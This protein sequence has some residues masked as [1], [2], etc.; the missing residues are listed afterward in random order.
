MN[1][2]RNGKKGQIMLAAERLFTS[3]R[4]H[5]IRLDDV[6]REAKVGK[7]TIYLYFPGKDELFFQTATNGLD[8]LCTL[9][10]DRPEHSCFTEEITWACGKISEFFETR[11]QLFRMMDDEDS[12]L[13]LSRGN[14]GQRW[15]GKRKP[16]V[17]AVSAIIQRG[18]SD[19]RIRADINPEILA[20]FL[21]G[22]LRTWARDLD[23]K[24]DADSA[25]KLIVEL[26]CNGAKR[27]GV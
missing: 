4:F 24:L 2:C 3:Q 17:A 11:K 16:L 13:C 1:E 10:Q 9:L 15:Q 25:K 21:L 18:I 26:F 20:E 5:E 23:F 22:I 12:R 8:E 14:M 6:A 7:G 19:N 27:N